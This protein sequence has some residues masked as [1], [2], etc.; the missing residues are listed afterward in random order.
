MHW[1]V[2]K[3][4]QKGLQQGKEYAHKIVTRKLTFGREN[5]ELA[6]TISCQ[7]NMHTAVREKKRLYNDHNIVLSDHTISSNLHTKEKRLD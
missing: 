6:S 7:R 4:V 1:E 2:P 5:S 3:D